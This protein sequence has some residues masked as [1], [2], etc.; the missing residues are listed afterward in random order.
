MKETGI[1][2]LLK[3]KPRDMLKAY[4]LLITHT[5]NHRTIVAMRIFSNSDSSI[6]L[7]EIGSIIRPYKP[8]FDFKGEFINENHR[9]FSVC[10]VRD[11]IQV[12]IGILGWL[13]REDALRLC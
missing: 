13:R 6:P 9:F 3:L 2:Y 12:D 5:Y 7:A 8:T 1:N 10:K 11:W 4:Y